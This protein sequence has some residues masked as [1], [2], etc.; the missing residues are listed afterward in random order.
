MFMEVTACGRNWPLFQRNLLPPSSG[1]KKSW[2]QQ[3]H[4]QHW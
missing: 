2:R 4:T 3:V 1:W